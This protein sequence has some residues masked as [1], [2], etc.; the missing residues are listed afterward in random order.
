M[1][2][3]GCTRVRGPGPMTSLLFDKLPAG[4]VGVGPPPAAAALTVSDLQAGGSAVDVVVAERRG[5]GRV[6][7]VED[8]RLLA[9]LLGEA[10]LGEALVLHQVG[11]VGVL[12]AVG[13]RQRV[14]QPKQTLILK[15]P[16]LFSA[17]RFRH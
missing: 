4:G 8:V 10:L 17:H 7:R 3:S 1:L 6:V 5:A 16:F 12:P 15:N 13:Q 14:L 2:R 9:S 11:V